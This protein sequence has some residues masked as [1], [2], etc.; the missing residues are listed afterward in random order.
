MPSLS[1]S[2]SLSMDSRMMV[3]P[4]GKM[5]WWM[6]RSL[7]LKERPAKTGE[8]VMVCPLGRWTRVGVM[9]R[10][11]VCKIPYSTMHESACR[12][13]APRVITAEDR[14]RVRPRPDDNHRIY[15]P[16]SPK[17]TSELP[18]RC[19]LDTLLLHNWKPLPFQPIRGAGGSLT[20]QTEEAAA[21]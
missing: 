19:N 11:H 20:D 17:K 3:Q 4:G 9:V 15:I 21:I 10:S 7:A 8:T 2:L 14:H 5:E 13:S 18:S 6:L 1:L 12:A 16:L